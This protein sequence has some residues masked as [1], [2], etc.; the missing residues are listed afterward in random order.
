MNDKFTL[1]EHDYRYKVTTL[2]QELSD[3]QLN[4]LDTFILNPR[5]AQI[6]DEIFTLQNNCEHRLV[7]ENGICAICDKYVDK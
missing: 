2:L 5:V 6:Q 4:G 3:E 7:D 1:F